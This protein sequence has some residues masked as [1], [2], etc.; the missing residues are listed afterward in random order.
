MPVELSEGR[1]AVWADV[2]ARAPRLFGSNRDGLDDLGR[3]YPLP[4]HDTTLHGYGPVR[5]D[6]ATVQFVSGAVPPTAPAPK[7]AKSATS[8]RRAGPGK[9]CSR[10]G[11]RT[12]PEAPFA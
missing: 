10:V 4:T 9:S 6:A 1:P 12:W 5:H 7:G 11:T 8:V 2:L 3:L